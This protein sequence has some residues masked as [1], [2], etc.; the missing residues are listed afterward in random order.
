MR[1]VGVKCKCIFTINHRLKC[2]NV[3]CTN[4][5]PVLT[6]NER[7]AA[8]RS[9]REL[10]TTTFVAAAEKVAR[11]IGQVAKL[12]RI[13]TRQSAFFFGPRRLTFARSLARSQPFLLQ[14]LR[15]RVLLVVFSL[16]VLLLGKVRAC[17]VSVLQ[18]GA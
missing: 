7:A 18:D 17:A 2:L 12:R 14:F 11:P 15:K 16:C 6:K 1:L 8:Q 10:V 13:N 9:D 4:R 3:L 5:S